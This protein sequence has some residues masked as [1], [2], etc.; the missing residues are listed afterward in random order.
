MEA[1][2]GAGRAGGRACGAARGG[3]VSSLMTRQVLPTT[4]FG[5][6]LK[7]WDRLRRRCKSRR[8]VEAALSRS[9]TKMHS[10]RESLSKSPP[11][12]SRT[13]AI[14]ADTKSFP[15]EYKPRRSTRARKILERKAV[16]DVPPQQRPQSRPHNQ[17]QNNVRGEPLQC[18]NSLRAEG[19][20]GGGGAA[21]GRDVPL[22]ISCRALSVPRAGGLYRANNKL[23]SP[24]LVWETY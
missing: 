22:S 12:E 14:S 3:R 23:G 19:I 15:V 18:T 17:P 2:S 1:I 6:S 7:L 20:S 10:L 13:F 24:P 8:A 11:S 21:G 4:C 5:G 16:L 9:R